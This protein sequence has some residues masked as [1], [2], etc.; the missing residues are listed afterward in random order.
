MVLFIRDVIFM[1]NCSTVSLPYIYIY[2]YKCE[3]NVRNLKTRSSSYVLY[4]SEKT[5][6]IRIFLRITRDVI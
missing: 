2:I 6:V 3:R 1:K 5:I 4:A